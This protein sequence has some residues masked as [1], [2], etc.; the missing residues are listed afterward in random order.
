M[1][2]YSLAPQVFPNTNVEGSLGM[3]LLGWK[4]IYIY[5]CKWHI[6]KYRF[7]S[8][9]SNI[10][11]QASQGI[12]LGFGIV[13]S[14]TKLNAPSKYKHECATFCLSLRCSKHCSTPAAQSQ[15]HHHQNTKAI[16]EHQPSPPTAHHRHHH[17]QHNQH[18]T[19]RTPA[20]KHL[21][22]TN[23]KPSTAK[24]TTITKR[25]EPR[26]TKTPEKNTETLKKSWAWVVFSIRCSTL[27][28]R[29]GLEVSFH[30]GL[31]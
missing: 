11:H 17:H 23:R 31:R 29:S 3:T 2:Q 15:E 5:I 22:N 21:Q 9:L 13:L 24:T 19:S 14:D 16:S 6:Y 30:V 25:P 26:R 12:I 8:L 18:T 27:V 4:S 20:L 10:I 1:N 28:L 7:P